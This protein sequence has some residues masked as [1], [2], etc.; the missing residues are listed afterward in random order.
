MMHKF[1][2]MFSVAMLALGVLNTVNAKTVTTEMVDQKLSWDELR[3]ILEHDNLMKFEVQ[4]DNVQLYAT[5]DHP[6]W[7]VLN[8]HVPKL[9]VNP[10]FEDRILFIVN[11]PEKLCN[12]KTV[13]YWNAKLFDTHIIKS[14]DVCNLVQTMNLIGGVS[15]GN[16]RSTII[17]FAGDVK[18]ILE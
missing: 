12:E 18:R 5:G 3:R 9:G 4:L 10:S 15:E 7:K 8:I 16:I 14:G 1:M 17:F 13:N 11:L 6:V 2:Q